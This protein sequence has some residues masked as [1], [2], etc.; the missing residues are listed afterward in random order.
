LPVNLPATVFVVVHFPPQS[1]SVLP[2][3]LTR[4]GRL[5]AVHASDGEAIETG[6]IY[7][8]PPDF[9]MVLKR[10]SISVVRGPR[11]NHS[12]P[13]IDPLFRSAA[14]TYGPRVVGTILSGTLGDGTAGLAAVKRR[15]GVALVQDPEEALFPDMP[16]NAMQ[17]VRVDYVLPLAEIP[18]L[19]TR[20]AHEPVEEGIPPMSDEMK[21]ETNIAQFDLATLESEEKPG[22][23]SGFACPDCGGN[24]WELQDSNLLRFRCRVGHA[25][26]TDALLAAQDGELE[27]ALWVALR[28][29]EE[30]A[31]LIRRLASRAHESKLD[32]AATN[33]AARAREAEQHAAV[34]RKLLMNDKNTV[35][36]EKHEASQ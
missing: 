29:L 24:L 23:L 4:A 15:G 25:F 32:F 5:P 2:H 36:V 34:I 31:L 18:P 33:F 27:T 6:R 3:L 12:R 20:L 11:E 16:R 19:L 7:I 14:L 17:Y 35:Q 28:T 26:S 1:T 21:K 22:V 10:G 9:H 13:A 8:A 30:R